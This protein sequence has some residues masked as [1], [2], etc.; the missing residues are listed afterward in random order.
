VAWLW[1]RTE[2]LK[3]W[4]KRLKTNKTRKIRAKAFQTA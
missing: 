3:K 1:G 2:K 4:L